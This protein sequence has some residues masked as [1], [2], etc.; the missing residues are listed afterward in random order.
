MMSKNTNRPK[1]SGHIEVILGRVDGDSERRG[2]DVAQ[3]PQRR[4]R[5]RRRR[6]RGQQRTRAVPRAFV[7]QV[8]HPPPRPHARHPR[9]ARVQPRHHIVSQPPLVRPQVFTQLTL[10]QAQ[11]HVTA[12]SERGTGRRAGHRLVRQ[13]VQVHER[14]C[15]LPVGDDGGR[16]HD[17]GEERVCALEQRGVSARAARERVR[18]PRCASTHVCCRSEECRWTRQITTLIALSLRP[19]P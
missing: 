11:K 7:Q 8:P 12:Q 2:A 10:K 3:R 15:R 9:Y 19:A 5:Q 13:H 1:H 16:H 14:P 4:E 6:R 17:T 18:Q